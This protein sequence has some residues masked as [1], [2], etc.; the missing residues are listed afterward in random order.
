M[1]NLWWTTAVRSMHFSGRDAAECE[2]TMSEEE[3]V[4]V[5][6]KI[7]RAMIEPWDEVEA[8]ANARQ[9][10]ADDTRGL[11]VLPAEF[12]KDAI[13]E[14]A[15]LWTAGIDA[16]EYATFLSQLFHRITEGHPPDAY[17]WLPTAQIDHGGYTSPRKLRADEPPPPV[18]SRGGVS[19]GGVVDL[20]RLDDENN[21]AEERHTLA[22]SVATAPP[23]PPK[24]PLRGG[25][26][27]GFESEAG[28]FAA[29][30]ELSERRRPTSSPTKRAP[31]A[32]PHTA[33][34]RLDDGSHR[35]A[36]LQAFRAAAA[37]AAAPPPT[38]PACK[39]DDA[40]QRL[41]TSASS[42]SLRDG[43]ESAFS[44]LADR[45]LA[46]AMRARARSVES[47]GRPPPTAGMGAKG[48]DGGVTT[49]RRAQQE[50][51]AERAV[52]ERAATGSAAAGCVAAGHGAAGRAVPVPRPPTGVQ[53]RPPSSAPPPTAHRGP[54]APARLDLTLDLTLGAV[55]VGGAAA[56]RQPLS[57]VR[58]NGALHAAVRREQMTREVAKVLRAPGM[59]AA[60][61]R[62]ASRGELTEPP[63]RRRR[64]THEAA[65][66]AARTAAQTTSVASSC[67][68][69]GARVPAA[70]AAR[71]AATGASAA[72]RAPAE[73]AAITAGLAAA[74]VAQ[75]GGGLG[76]SSL[77]CNL[78]GWSGL[79]HA[80]PP[81]AR[82]RPGYPEPAQGAG[83]AC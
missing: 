49:I 41:H 58:P 23:S 46:A 69:A 20:L 40:R 22:L 48:L 21:V 38:A 67:A 28:A 33:L 1:L 65:R 2:L 13:F 24:S 25:R 51:A 11:D 35:A 42:C 71:E 60:L 54:D 12:F 4:K 8:E 7:Y 5:S 15:D 6:M 75:I 63:G 79:A 39:A 27:R 31:P 77:S 74:G 36:R 83:A 78:G 19:M 44:A 37:S 53:P 17:L 68:P 66:A 45:A 55:A 57:A 10:W 59:G 50:A 34:P 61:V 80:L 76:S 82:A 47:Q 43:P 64:T 16:V 81:I 73:A 9:E 29:A 70:A 30:H 56:P 72:A 32:A 3:Y 26:P 14:L 62:K 52:A 18:H